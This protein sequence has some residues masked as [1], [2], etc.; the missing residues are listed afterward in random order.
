MAVTVISNFIVVYFGYCE[1]NSSHFIAGCIEAS[2]DCRNGTCYYCYKVGCHVFFASQTSMTR[3]LMTRASVLAM[4]RLLD[5]CQKM[6]EPPCEVLHNQKVWPET[7]VAQ[8]VVKDGDTFSITVFTTEEHPPAKLFETLRCAEH[9]KKVFEDH[10]PLQ[11]AS[12]WCLL[13]LRLTTSI[14]AVNEGITVFAGLEKSS[15]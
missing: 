8:R 2:S 5:M 1:F 6:H 13:V 15:N 4:V 3:S 9:A 10:S 7:D 14:L 11:D 12:S